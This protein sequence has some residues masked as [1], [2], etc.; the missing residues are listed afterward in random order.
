MLYD[1]V[2]LSVETQTTK[3]SKRQL[4]H[5]HKFSGMQMKELVWPELCISGFAMLSVFG[6][7][8]RWYKYRP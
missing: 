1:A 6:K 4:C 8:P 5:T 2:I 3:N 7:S